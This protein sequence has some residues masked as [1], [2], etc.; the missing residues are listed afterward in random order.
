MVATE[1]SLTLSYRTAGTVTL[2]GDDLY[3]DVVRIEPGAAPASRSPASPSG[4]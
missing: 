4:A 3:E 1:D 2:T